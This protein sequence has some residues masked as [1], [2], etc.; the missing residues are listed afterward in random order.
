[1]QKILDIHYFKDITP[2]TQTAKG[3]WL[4]I[5]AGKNLSLKKG[6]P[7]IIPL[8]FT[9]QLPK[10]YQ[11]IIESNPITAEKRGIWLGHSIKI[12]KK[13]HANG[14]NEWGLFAYPFRDTHIKMN[15][16]IGQFHV[17]GPCPLLTLREIDTL[18][19]H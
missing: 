15:D 4:D 19:E 7:A 8:G 6:K 17:V 2:L 12:L 16:C 5:R 9:M 18:S 11:V 14:S 1:M 10:G 3:A 13:S